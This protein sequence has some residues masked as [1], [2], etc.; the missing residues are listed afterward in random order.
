MNKLS[1]MDAREFTTYLL[2]RMVIPRHEPGHVDAEL[3]KR[4]SSADPVQGTPEP[5]KVEELARKIARSIYPK[6][7]KS[8]AMNGLSEDE[9]TQEIVNGLRPYFSLPSPK[10]ENYAR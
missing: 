4:L 8:R 5:P 9:L 6:A 3:M 7:I 1:A 10:G 2:N